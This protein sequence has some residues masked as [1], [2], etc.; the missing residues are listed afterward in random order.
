MASNVRTFNLRLQQYADEVPGDRITKIHRA[1]ALEGLK[2]V[3]QMTPVDTG[4]ARGNWQVSQDE[5]VDTVLDAEDKDGAATIA[6]GGVEIAR[7]KP[8]S[9][10]W[11]ANNLDYISALEN[12]HSKQAPRGMLSVTMQRLRA[13]ASR[14]RP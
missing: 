13:I 11:I 4:R 1:L 12:G 6:G 8:F 14:V 7:I 2:G 5:P 9:R 3:V 10:S